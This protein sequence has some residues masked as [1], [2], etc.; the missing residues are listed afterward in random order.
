MCCIGGGGVT[1]TDILETRQGPEVLVAS[2]GLNLPLTSVSK[3][4]ESNLLLLFHYTWSE[5]CFSSM[6]SKLAWG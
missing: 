5:Q 6:G 3:G 4:L 2:H 1:W